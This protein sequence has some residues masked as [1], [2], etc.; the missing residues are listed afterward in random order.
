ME[1]MNPILDGLYPVVK[2][3]L[4]ELKDLFVDEYIHLGNDEVYYAC[5]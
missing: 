2:E 5:W 1:I 4:S 3:I